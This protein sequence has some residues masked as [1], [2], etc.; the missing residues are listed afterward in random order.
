MKGI[1]RD[2][3]VAGT[4]TTATTIRWTLIFLIN[5]PH[6]QK[7]VLIY[8]YQDD[9]LNRNISSS[10]DVLTA[11][12]RSPVIINIKDLG[13]SLVQTTKSEHRFSAKYIPMLVYFI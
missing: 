11:K 12:F 6:V 7:K 2:F 5:R 13:L 1:V 4:D 10:L 3:F 9:L 8:V